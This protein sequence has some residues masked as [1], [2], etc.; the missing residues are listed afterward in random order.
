MMAA[1]GADFRAPAE[2]PCCCVAHRKSDVAKL[3]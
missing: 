2:K 1:P 3:I